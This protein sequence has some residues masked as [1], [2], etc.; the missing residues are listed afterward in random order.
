VLSL[1]GLLRQR[2]SNLSPAWL[3]HTHSYTTAQR[4]LGGVS[5]RISSETV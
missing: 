2:G 4:F 1:L 5:E 3:A